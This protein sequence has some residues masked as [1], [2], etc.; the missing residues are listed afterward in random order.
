VTPP[1]VAVGYKRCEWKSVISS[2]ESS[3]WPKKYFVR[4]AQL[5]SWRNSHPGDVNNFD[6]DEQLFNRPVDAVPHHTAPE[7]RPIHVAPPCT[8]KE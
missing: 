8:E 4:Q 7:I 6:L 5:R 2:L 3:W 1:S